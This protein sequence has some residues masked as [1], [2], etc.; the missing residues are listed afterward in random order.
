MKKR[1]WQTTLTALSA[2][3]MVAASLTACGGSAKETGKAAETGTSAEM[4]AEKEAEIPEG[5]SVSQETDVT[6]APYIDI[7]TMDPLDA[8]DTMS[9]GVQRLVMDGLF[10]FD[11]EMRVI[12]LL[13]TGY[14]ANDDATEFTVTLREG[15]SFSDGTPFNADAVIA[16]ANRWADKNGG[17]KRTT[18]LSGVLAGTEKVDDTTVKFR[19]SQPF[20]AFINSLAH[21]ATLIMSPAVIAEGNQACATSPVGTGQ[22]KFV[23]WVQ[24]DHTKLELNRDWWGYSARKEDGSSFVASD[25]GFKTLTLRPVKEGA[26]RTAMIQSGDAQFI[27]DIPSESIST[28]Q[29]D[30]NVNVSTQEGLVTYFLMMNNQKKPFDDIRVRQA[31]AYAIDKNAM[32][33][34][35]YNGLGTPA[36]SLMGKQ[37]QF[38][39]ENTPFEYR[40]EKAKELLKEAGYEQ[41]FSVDFMYRNSSTNQKVMEFLKQQL[42]QVG[43]NL[44]LQAMESAVLNQKVQDFTG[45]GAEAEVNLYYTGWSSS[46]GDADWA[47]RPILTRESE[48]PM[49]YNISYFENAEVDQLIRDALN[50][51]DT[52]KRRE[53]YAKVQDI[54]WQELPMVPLFHMDNTI[55]T[56]GK[57]S[58]V[59]LY[60]DAAIN[61]RNARMAK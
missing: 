48:P 43:I 34:I 7:T 16:N 18:F 20:G 28:L 45:S 27:W 42:S 2:A 36:T 56:S 29:A 55:A 39:K 44:N 50:T 13:A 3:L 8:S 46:T 47:L 19:L 52:E 38:Y 23:E 12:P 31:M 6:A 40:P 9:G 11:D 24:G 53:D 57:L 32:V 37:T 49:S 60:P 15:V 35:C 10:G 51:A 41:G 1:K 22:Y 61:L 17:L 54:V 25:A 4:P 30:S 21:P 14:S 58:G 5:Q 59:K 26:T 33:Q